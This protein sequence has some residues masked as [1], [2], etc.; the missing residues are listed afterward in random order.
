[1][2]K[3][4]DAP[5]LT[6]ETQRKDQREAARAYRTRPRARLRRNSFRSLGGGGEFLPPSSCSLLPDLKFQISLASF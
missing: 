1:M 3:P 6:A 2:S 5:V 4:A